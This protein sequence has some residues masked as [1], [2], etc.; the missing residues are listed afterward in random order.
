MTRPFQQSSQNSGFLQKAAH[1][2]DLRQLNRETLSLA[3]SFLRA[4]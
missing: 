4:N 3:I 1:S 2:P